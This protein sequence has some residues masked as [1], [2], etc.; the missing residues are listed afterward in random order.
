MKIFFILVLCL[1]FY[2]TTLTNIVHSQI[3]KD[4]KENAEKG[5]AEAQF[6]L[7]LMYAKGRGIDQ[8]YAKARA[9]YEKAAAQGFPPA[10]EILKT[11]PK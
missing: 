11:F 2:L 6:N 4:T 10:Q 9:W 8:D 1:A 7:G 5:N 3:F